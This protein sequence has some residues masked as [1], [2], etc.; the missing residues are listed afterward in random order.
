VT[1][2]WEYSGTGFTILDG[3]GTHS[4]TADFASAATSGTLSVKAER[5]GQSSSPLTMEIT[6]IYIPS[7]PGSITGDSSPSAGTSENLYNVPSVINITYQWSYDGT[8][9]SLIEDGASAS[10]DFLITAQP[11]IL[12]VIGEN[13]C[14]SSAASTLFIDVTPVAP[15]SPTL[16]TNSTS[17]LCAGSSGITYTVPQVSGVSYAW[18]YSGTGFTITEGDGTN[19]IVADFSSEAISGTLSV[20][21]IRSGLTSEDLTMLIEVNSAP[22][23]PG[24][25]SGNTSPQAGSFGNIFS[26]SSVSNVSYVWSYSGNDA[27]LISDGSDATLDFSIDAQPG[28][29]SVKAQ[30]GCGSSIESTLLIEVVPVAPEP[31]GSFT[32]STSSVCAGSSDIVYSVPAKSGVSY[33]WT[34]TG[35]GFTLSEG[36]GT[37]SI[38]VDLA[39]EA[40]SG[41][42]SVQTAR[43]GLTSSSL[44]I[45]ITVTAL[46]LDPGQIAGNI[47]P[48]AG[49]A[50]NTYMVEYV[51]GNSYEWTYT[52]DDATLTANGAITNLTFSATAQPGTLSVVAVNACGRSTPSTLTIN[53]K[54]ETV[55]GIETDYANVSV[56][57]NPSSGEFILHVPPSLR[58]GEI[59]IADLFG[60]IV[61]AGFSTVSESKIDLSDLAKGTYLLKTTRDRK[62][63]TTKIIVK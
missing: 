55:T 28:T 23:S 51:E 46:P 27:N 39:S 37:N 4:I 7:S 53:V 11:G 58:G 34:Y 63:L 62:G 61:Y 32:N 18:D 59:Q 20:K 45:E 38:S 13:V 36:N 16:F 47:L 40:T 43:N 41:T 44:T 48:E 9:A 50:D 22:T 10:L 19:S 54:P 24:S 33:L 52:N 8:D 57:P 17:S 42:L 30:N 26:V 56:Y 14:G 5:S 31:P 35:T 25:I 15:E 21:A 1:Y 3:D 29:L 49:S 12:T 2:V 60:R 6:V